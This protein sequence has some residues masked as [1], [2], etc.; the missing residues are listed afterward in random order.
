MHRAVT[1]V[2]S[3]LE[4]CQDLCQVGRLVREVLVRLGDD[5]R[6]YKQVPVC[7]SNNEGKEEAIGRRLCKAYKKWRQHG[8]KHNVLPPPLSLAHPGYRL[9]PVP[10]V[11]QQHNDSPACAHQRRLGL[12]DPGQPQRQRCRPLLQRQRQRCGPLLQ[13][14]LL[15]LLQG[16]VLQ[17]DKEARKRRPGI[18]LLREPASGG[19]ARGGMTAVGCRGCKRL[20]TER[21]PV[22]NH[23]PP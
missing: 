13:R 20:L 22:V 14:L 21:S 5:Q 17:P 10:A 19:N 23:C 3:G 6:Q 4:P 1:D 8:R 7:I 18:A 12:E 16:R 11:D 2:A 9:A 15:W